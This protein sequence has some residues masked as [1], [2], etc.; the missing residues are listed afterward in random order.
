MSPVSICVKH[1]SL[2][3]SF[4]YAKYS[5]LVWTDHILYIYS[6]VDGRLSHFYLSAPMNYAAIN[7]N[8]WTSFHADVFSVLLVS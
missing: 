4:F 1:V 3:H 8:S 6:P 2:L 7:K 5:S